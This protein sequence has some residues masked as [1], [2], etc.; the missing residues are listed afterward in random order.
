[1]DGWASTRRLGKR[2]ESSGLP[3][4]VLACS[5][6]QNRGGGWLGKEGQFCQFKHSLEFTEPGLGVVGKESSVLSIRA[7]ICSNLQN[8]G[9][10]W[11]AKIRKARFLPIRAL[12]CSNLQNRGG[13]GRQGQRKLGWRSAK[14]RETRICKFGHANAMPRYGSR[15]GSYAITPVMARKSEFADEIKIY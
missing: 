7:L 10:G 14:S 6:L 3:I 13:G 1:M 8:R 11:S 12:A 2:K 15:I 5:N 9:W 4:R